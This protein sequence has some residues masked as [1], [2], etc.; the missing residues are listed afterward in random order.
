MPFLFVVCQAGAEKALKSELSRVHP[1]L[2]FAYS[3]PG[4]V[5]FKLP[6]GTRPHEMELESVFARAFGESLKTLKSDW[7]A[8]VL[9][10]AHR[11]AAGKPLR[12]HVFERDRHHP[13][14]EPLGFVPGALAD[15][16][17]ELMGAAALPSGLF[18][19]DPVAQATG[20][21]VLDVIVVEEGE[22]WVGWHLHSPRHH[23]YPGGNPR[24]SLPEE[25][26]SRAYLKL[27]EALLWSRAPFRA[28]DLA[29]EIG[30][31]PGGASYALLEQGFRVIGIDPAIVQPVVSMAPNYQ[32]LSKSVMFVSADELPEEV[33]WLLLDMN[34]EPN[35]SM[36]GAE[37]IA[38][39]CPQLL[40]VILTLKL[41]EWELADQIP[42]YLDR[43]RANLGLARV[44][45]VQLA[46]NRR[47][48][49][50]YGLTRKGMARALL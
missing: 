31:A 38:D 39:M 1:E 42:E 13:G 10:E 6:D 35:V 37:R 25:A 2:K 12:L 14:E 7:V 27:R 8:G 11:L 33:D 30:S 43:L 22:W 21:L 3:R 20:E 48:I 17:R 28:G 24:L 34:A 23:A 19:D 47:E 46:H 41:N 44:R 50:V 32:H 18:F 26:P 36:Y 15:Q 4:F 49:C 5:T 16:A 29:V 45:A 40:G 9:A